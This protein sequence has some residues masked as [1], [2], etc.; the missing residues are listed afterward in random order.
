[1]ITVYGHRVRQART[2]RASAIKP[3]AQL[4][5][6]SP[7]AWTALERL[8]TT[9]LP[10]LRVRAL[11]VAL[12]FPLEFF[13]SPP[14][15]PVH[16]G[17]L[18]FRAKKSIK[19]SEVDV[20]TAFSEMAQELHAALA[21]TAT[22]PPV[23]LP[24]SLPTGSSPAEAARCTRAALDLPPSEPI[25]HVMHAAERAGVLV[26][27][28]DVELADARHDAISVWIGDFQEQPLIVALPVNSWERTR[29]S[30]AHELGHLV[31]H[32]GGIPTADV[33]A[34]A[35]F[36]ANEFLFPERVL[37]EEWPPAATLSSLMPLKRRWQMSLASLIMHGRS[38][39]LIDAE[40]A[41]GLFKQLS[42]RRDVVT[43]VTWRI[44]E[45]G[46]AEQQPERPRLLAAMT[47]R[48]LDTTPSAALF[49]ALAGGWAEDLM[50]EV[51]AGQRPAPAVAA[52]QAREARVLSA[53]KS[54]VVQ[55]H[56]RA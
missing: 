16:R 33:E 5:D 46:W 6:L 30:V 13:Q 2:I 4:L 55:L 42:A 17:S 51:V 8:P 31:L 37:R 18:L 25:S 35:N 47:E 12:D 49:S 28:A 52:A 3:L 45:P 10:P 14:G 11:A 40:R 7:S 20:L 29:W 38:H 27:V 24:M 9:L 41:E 22:Q 43:G 54:N 36:F 48:G 39:D 50:E 32:H 26:I 56:R 15:P 1:M 21:K 19:A 44:Q 34:E 53:A 23:R